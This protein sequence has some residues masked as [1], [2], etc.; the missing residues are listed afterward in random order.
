VT[1]IPPLVKEDFPDF[2]AQ[3]N[4]TGHNPNPTLQSLEINLSQELAKN[5]SEKLKS[6]EEKLENA[7]V[8]SPW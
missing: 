4:A 5:I 7:N 3:N 1:T 2:P 6:T 8:S